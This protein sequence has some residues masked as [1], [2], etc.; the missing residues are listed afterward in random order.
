[1]GARNDSF[2][3]VVAADSRSPRDGRCI[4]QLGW[5]DSKKEGV[6]FDLQQDRIEHWKSQGAV[7]SA[8][9]KS[10]MRRARKAAKP[11]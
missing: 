3:R 6:N 11:A 2:F 4:E 9:V 10:L 5:Y 1:M 7:I 8:T